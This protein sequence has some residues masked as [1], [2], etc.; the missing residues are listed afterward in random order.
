VTYF[1]LSLVVML[2]LGLL[3][4]ILTSCAGGWYGPVS[5]Y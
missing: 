3:M 2:G 5:I 1:A 4:G